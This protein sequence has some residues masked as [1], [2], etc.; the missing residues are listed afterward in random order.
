VLQLRILG[1]RCQLT[2]APEEQL[3]GIRIWKEV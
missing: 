1:C 2:M 3:L